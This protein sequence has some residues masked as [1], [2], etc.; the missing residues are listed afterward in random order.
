[1]LIDDS[2]S[3]AFALAGAIGSV[4]TA[5]ALGFLYYQS[6][7]TQK[8]IQLAQQQT[9]YT[10]EEMDSTL[11]PWIGVIDVEIQADEFVTFTVKN[12]GRILAKIVRMRKVI[13]KKK[14][15]KDQLCS[16]E[17]EDKEMLLFP[18]AIVK[19]SSILPEDSENL[20]VAIMIEYEYANN[21][22]GEY[23]LIGKRI[24]DTGNIIYEETFAD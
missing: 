4:A 20:Y 1:M 17:A 12:Y 9:N 16:A 24:G 2:W 18:D 15:T 21:K 14:I 11:R 13:D 22:H 19:M 7:Q 5:G 23:G 10:R 6:R 3:F 8:Q